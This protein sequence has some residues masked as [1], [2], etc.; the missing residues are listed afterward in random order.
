MIFL[1]SPKFLQGEK[2]LIKMGLFFT[3]SGGINPARSLK[4]VVLPEPSG[5]INAVLCPFLSEKEMSYREGAFSPL[6]VLY[7]FLTSKRFKF[8][9]LKF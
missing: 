9:P 8:H 1:I 4:R 2:P 6:K 7:K 3:L 5:P